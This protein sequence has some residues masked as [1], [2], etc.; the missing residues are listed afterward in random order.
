M[1]AAVI[2]L[3]RD[4]CWV[5]TFIAPDGS[6]GGMRLAYSSEDVNRAAAI[7]RVLGQRLAIRLYS[8]Y[9]RT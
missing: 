1:T 7:A 3:R 2:P 5:V 8:D 6:E 4:D 9:V